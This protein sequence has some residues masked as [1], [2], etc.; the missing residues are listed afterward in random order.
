MQ[1]LSCR[2]SVNMEGQIEVISLAESQSNCFRRLL[3]SF[4]Q[5]SHVLLGDLRFSVLLHRSV[6]ELAIT[7]ELY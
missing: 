1:G 4:P 3:G 6:R 2:K 5:I 7:A